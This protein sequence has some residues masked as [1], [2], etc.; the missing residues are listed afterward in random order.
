MPYNM[1]LAQAERGTAANAIGRDTFPP[2]QLIYADLALAS[3]DNPFEDSRFTE[4]HQLLSAP[5]NSC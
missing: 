2:P 5:S 4:A 1:K 3:Y